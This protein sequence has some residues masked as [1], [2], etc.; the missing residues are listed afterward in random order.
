MDP[1][2]A[3]VRRHLRDRIFQNLEHIYDCRS[4][5]YMAGTLYIDCYRP[6]PREDICL[7]VWGQMSETENGG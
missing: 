5:L 2:P 7:S 4:V 3:L 1:N 6:L